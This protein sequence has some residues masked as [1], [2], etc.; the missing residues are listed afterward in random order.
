MITVNIIE[1]QL[2]GSYGEKTFSIPFSIEVYE[3]L[4]G[5][6]EEADSVSTPDELTAI[7]DTIESLVSQDLSILETECEYIKVDPKN[8][9]FYLHYNDV[10][11]SVP[12]PQAL[13]DRIM[14][15]HD[16]KLD[17]MPLI[18]MW[19]R[20][21]RNPNLD[22]K[23]KGARFAEKFFNFI[24]MK[25][26]HPELRDGF[27]EKGFS[28]EE[29]EKRAKVYQMKVTKEG[30]L[31]GYKVSKEILHK[32]EASEDGQ[33]AVQKP[34]YQKTFD[35]DTGKIT[36]EGLPTNVEDRLFEPAVMGQSGDA[37][38]CEGANGFSEQG[39][40]IRVGC[41]HALDSWDKV[42]IDDDVSC[43]PGLHFGGLH[44]IGRISGEIHNIFVDPMHVGAVPNDTTG[45]IRCKQYFVHSSLAGVN[46]AIYHSSEYAK[47]TDEEWKSMCQEAVKVKMAAIE[48]LDAKEAERNAL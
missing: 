16:K 10:T 34:R 44:Y 37:F 6:S 42:N 41:V 9:K 18:L 17:F 25:Y 45:A 27:L 26:L 35:P 33:E 23:G 47:L 20:F 11:S 36:S 38:S 28:Q 30:L 21:L 40:F 48:A 15:S 1:D 46:G 13:V 12:M 7:Y 29:A 19:V 4:M 32:Y 3:K 22:K 31:N 14:E 8:G 24:N 43:V 5:L 2:T 39:H